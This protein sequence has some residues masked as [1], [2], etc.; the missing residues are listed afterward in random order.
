MSFSGSATTLTPG[1][2]VLRAA[3]RAVKSG[4]TVTSYTAD[5]PASST[6]IRAVLPPFLPVSSSPCPSGITLTARIDGS[7]T[8]TSL[9][10]WAR[11]TITLRPASRWMPVSPPTAGPPAAGAVVGE[12]GGGIIGAGAGVGSPAVAGGVA[13]AAVGRSAGT[14]SGDG[15][16]VGIAPPAPLPAG[17]AGNAWPGAAF[18]YGWPFGPCGC[19]GPVPMSCPAVEPTVSSTPSEAAAAAQM[20]PRRLPRRPRV[21]ADWRATSVFAR[22][23]VMAFSRGWSGLL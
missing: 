19:P 7:A 18:G 10:M 9:A 20:A 3:R 23:L 11:R 22:G 2:A 5:R 12:V 17:W 21:G 8:E 14:I 15:T 1:K 13:G 16:G 4:E 6:A